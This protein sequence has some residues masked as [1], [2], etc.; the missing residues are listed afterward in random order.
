MQE[1][2]G[3]RRG[4]GAGRP[5]NAASLSQ[6]QNG[7]P[8]GNVDRRNQYTNRPIIRRRQE[9]YVTLDPAE[10]LDDLP[11]H[12][13]EKQPEQDEKQGKDHEGK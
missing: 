8:N 6:N 1:E 9:A 10:L 12:Q 5:G 3:D 13:T 4:I 7:N 11:E 2:R